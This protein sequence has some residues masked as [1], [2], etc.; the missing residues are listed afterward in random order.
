MVH[1]QQ[2]KIPHKDAI[3]TILPLYQPI[4][5]S[6]SLAFKTHVSGGTLVASSASLRARGG[7]HNAVLFL[8]EDGMFNIQLAWLKEGQ[9]VCFFLSRVY[10]CKCLFPLYLYRENELRPLWSCRTCCSKL[11]Q[12]VS[13]AWHFATFLSP[14]LLGFQSIPSRM[15]ARGA[16]GRLIHDKLPCV[17][18]A[19][20][21]LQ[22]ASWPRNPANL[23][24]LLATYDCCETESCNAGKDTVY[25]NIKWAFEPLSCGLDMSYKGWASRNTRPW[26][27]R[28][29][30]PAKLEHSCHP[31][32]ISPRNGNPLVI[33]V[34]C[35]SCM[36]CL[37]IYVL[38]F[39]SPRSF[40]E[41]YWPRFC[42]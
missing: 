21:Q 38:A 12:P 40:G 28:L 18:T 25:R 13:D 29:Q 32:I 35:A 30:H 23:Y 5:L 9:Y 27:H 3:C 8:T 15:I 36:F 1:L 33:V 24:D 26:P 2:S 7:G 14:L 11:I 17:T 42:A 10:G 41:L 16:G 39:V 4:V 34:P 6:C 31:Q 22:L 20:A 19:L 37:C